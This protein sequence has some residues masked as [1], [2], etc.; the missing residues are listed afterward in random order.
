MTAVH[1]TR[2]AAV[3]WTLSLL[4]APPDVPSAI[5][6]SLAG[7]LEIQVPGSVLG[8]LIAA[9]HASDV[10]IDGHESEVAWAAASTWVYRTAVPRYGDGAHVRV[11]FEG[12]DTFATVRVDGNEE[13]RTDDMF[14]RWEVDLGVDHT[15]GEWVVEVEF[16]PAEAV[17]RARQAALP[18][19]RADMYEI[20]YNQVRKMA[21][22]FGWDWGPTT[23]TAGLF[24]DVIVERVRTGRVVSARVDAGWGDGAVLRGQ[25][26]VEGSVEQVAITVASKDGTVVTQERVGAA[27]ARAGFSFDVPGALRWDV[28]ERGDQPLYDV[29]VA[30]LDASSE[31]VDEVRRQVGFR[32]VELVQEPDEVG[33]SFEIHVNGSRVWCRGFNWIPADVLPERISRE[34]LRALIEQ[35]VATGANM[36]RVWGGGVVESDDFYDL[37]DELGVL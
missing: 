29:T 30:A 22:S 26:D 7:G 15:P 24:R 6:D 12:V 17:A 10:T 3:D 4:Q 27:D 19:P 37:C 31:T 36:L 25:I 21:C 13:L 2:T 33:T 34:H 11:V 18:M 28:R 5:E 8:A 35:A 16:A 1:T 20:P 9:G 14:H 23:M 32:A